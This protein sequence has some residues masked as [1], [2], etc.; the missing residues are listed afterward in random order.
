M[1]EPTV[2]TIAHKAMLYDRSVAAL[3]AKRAEA[4]KGNQGKPALTVV[5]P[6]ATPR[7][8]NAAAANARGAIQRLRERGDM[9]SLVEAMKTL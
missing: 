3:A 8:T 1:V 9:A 5:Q 6:G 7:P 4:A 2:I